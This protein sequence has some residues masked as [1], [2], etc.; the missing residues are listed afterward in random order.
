MSQPFVHLELATPDL[1]KAKEFY[2][3]LCGWTFDDVN[4]G[5]ELGTY[6]TF[7]PSNG[8]GGGIY[9][10]PGAPTA[11]LPY[12]GVENLKDATDKAISLGAKALMR[13]QEVPGHGSFSVLIDPTGASIALWE[14]KKA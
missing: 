8:P 5:G 4:M 12:I 14:A 10:M 9:T 11:W 3:K 2:G 7:K 1:A 6:S 13:E